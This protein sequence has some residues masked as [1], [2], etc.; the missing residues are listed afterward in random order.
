MKKPDELGFRKCLEKNGIKLRWNFE[1]K[2]SYL[3]SCRHYLDYYEKLYGEYMPK[4]KKA[5]ILEIGCGWGWFLYY[6]DNKGYKNILGVDPDAHRLSVINK[7]GIHKTRK[8]DAFAFLK[9]K[10]NFYDLI[11]SVYILEHVPKKKV[12][13][14]LRLAYRALKK[15]GRIIV[16]VP[17]MESPLNLRSRY[18]DFTHE[19]GFTVNSLLHVLYYSNFD[20]LKVKEEF[21]MPKAAEKKKKYK[22]AVKSLKGIYD[23]LCV[24]APFFFAETLIASG[25]KNKS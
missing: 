5:N 13:E 2:G 22:G 18:M 3:E 7:F 6:M 8:I 21:M 20:G 24:R 23:D 19:T 9:N 17:N 4:N 11:V 15:G 16:A 12:F 14:F 25:V 10:K 1:S